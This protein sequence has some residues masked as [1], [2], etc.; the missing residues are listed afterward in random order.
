MCNVFIKRC[1]SCHCWLDVWSELFRTPNGLSPTTRVTSCLLEYNI[2]PNSDG[3]VCFNKRVA[4]WCNEEIFRVFLV[5]SEDHQWR[6]EKRIFELCKEAWFPSNK[7]VEDNVKALTGKYY[8]KSLSIFPCIKYDCWM[9]ME[10]KGEFITRLC[11][12][13][14]LICQNF[15]QLN[16]KHV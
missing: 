10:L 15:G 8:L 4:F 11:N 13:P 12:Q 3:R 7:S 1:W 2:A 9:P 14:C 6:R 16:K 5:S